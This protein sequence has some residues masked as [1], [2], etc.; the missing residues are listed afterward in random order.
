M[1][2]NPKN[3]V[4]CILPFSE[5][6]DAYLKEVVDGSLA[7]PERRLDIAGDGPSGGQVQIWT[8]RSHESAEP[9]VV[10][11]IGRARAFGNPLD[12]MRAG[13]LLTQV[14]YM[15]LRS[16][17]S[18]S[19]SMCTVRNGNRFLTRARKRCE[20]GAVGILGAL[21][22]DG[23]VDNVSTETENG[24]LPQIAGGPSIRGTRAIGILECALHTLDTPSYE[25]A[26][27]G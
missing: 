11:D 27:Q 20:D 8:T 16:E 25:D 7:L 9:A 3:L 1:H 6:A 18:L 12:D 22:G 5:I 17:P 24:V 26:F 21:T 4:D 23:R 14:R 10:D 19:I 15:K 2:A 13:K